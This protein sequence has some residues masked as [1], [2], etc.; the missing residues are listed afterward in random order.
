MRET[1][2]GSLTRSGNPN[3]IPTTGPYAGLPTIFYNIGS[4]W[5]TDL[6]ISYDFTDQVG[7]TLSATNLFE[8]EP[9]LLPAPLL[10]AHQLYQYTNNGPIGA[11]GG[12]YS[13]TLRFSW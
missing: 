13:A 12:F 3:P 10:G 7:L 5:T 1:Y 6:N 2:Y 11:E 9:D 4:L 8:A